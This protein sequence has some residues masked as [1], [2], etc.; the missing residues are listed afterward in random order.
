[1]L[2][3]PLGEDGVQWSAIKL[4]FNLYT[5]PGF[6]G[7]LLNIINIIMVVLLFK[8]YSLHGAKRRIH[9]R[10]LCYYFLNKCMR[11]ENTEESKPLIEEN[12]KC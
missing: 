1:L 7:V 3:Q 4:Y 10:R 11:V 9:F 8:E 12:N 5:G 6:F 2:F